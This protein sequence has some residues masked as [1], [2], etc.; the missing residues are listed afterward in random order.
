MN[1]RPWLRMVLIAIA[2]ALLSTLG[3]NVV[4]PARPS[5]VP[6]PTS[7]APPDTTPPVPIMPAPVPPPPVVPPKPSPN[8]PAAIVRITFGNSG[9][10]ATVIGDRNADGTYD[11]LT[12]A[13]C[14]SSIGQR[15][16][17]RLKDGRTG[18]IRVVN[19]DRKADVCWCVTEVNSEVYPFAVLAATTPAIGTRVWHAGYGVDIPGNREDGVVEAGQDGN[20]QVRYRLSVSSGDSGGGICVNEKNEVLS[21]VCCTTARGQVAQVWGASPESCARARPTTMVMDDWKPIEIPQR[22]PAP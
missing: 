11:V 5:P 8:T 12:A 9:C 17:M 15:G 1:E 6:P 16:T 13:H 18:G 4:P 22:M 19:I 20:G 10:S 7:P 3:I 2:S 14:V 21:P